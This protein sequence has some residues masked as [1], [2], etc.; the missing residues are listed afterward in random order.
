MALVVAGCGDDGNGGSLGSGGSSGIS[1]VGGSSGGTGSGEVT[2]SGSGTSG[3]VTG[4]SSGAAETS[5]SSTG[6]GESSSTTGEGEGSSSSTGVEAEPHPLWISP[7]LWYSVDDQ[8]HYIEIDPADGT[9]AQLVTSTISTEMIS[10]QNGITMLE[11]GALLLSRESTGGTEIYYVEDPPTVASEIEVELLGSVPDGLRIEALYT[12]C[13]GLVYLMDTGADVGSATGNRL[14][15]FTGDYLGGDLSF[16]VITDLE[17]ASAPDIDD[18]GPG[19]DADG[20]I[21]DGQGFAIDTSNVYEFDYNTGTGTS[22]GNAGTWG[23]HALG[24]P[25]FDDGIARLYVFDQDANLREA[26]PVT[27]ATSDVLVTGPDPDGS[28]P[29]GWSGITGP[30]TECVTTL[31]PPG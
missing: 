2:G 13:Q 19:I 6:L 4:S 15:R 21:T 16:E 26:D 5:S 9:V 22:L 31:P 20:E 7:N 23:V 12:D 1:T 29:A 24:G 25:L 28:S 30:L 14:I 27:L 11:S 3:E 10:G 17:N 18:M 8:L